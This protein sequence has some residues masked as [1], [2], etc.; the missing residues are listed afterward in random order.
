MIATPLLYSGLVLL[1]L[2][3]RIE[4]VRLGEVRRGLALTCLRRGVLL[5]RPRRQWSGS[6][7]RHSLPRRRALACK[8]PLN[9]RLATGVGLSFFLSFLAE[10]AGCAGGRFSGGSGS[11]AK[12]KCA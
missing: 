8:G 7:A 10:E 12:D 1:A 9:T 5:R 3:G 6:R 4:H 2:R 11:A